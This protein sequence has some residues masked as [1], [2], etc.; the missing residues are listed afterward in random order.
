MKKYNY[1]Y[2]VYKPPRMPVNMPY[3]PV[4]TNAG[5]KTML[6]VLFILCFFSIYAGMIL[7]ELFSVKSGSSIENMWLLF[8]VLPLPLS[9]LILGIIFAGRGYKCKKNIVVG[10]IFSFLLVIY[11]SFTFTFADTY[12]SDYSFVEDIGAEIGVTMPKDGR[13]TIMNIPH[14]EDTYFM[15]NAEF[16]QKDE[17]VVLATEI[18]ADERWVRTFDTALMGE[19]PSVF[20]PLSNSDMQARH[21]YML[22]NTDLGTFNKVTSQSG[23]YRYIF[24]NYDMNNR[25]MMIGVYHMAIIVS[26]PQDNVFNELR[27]N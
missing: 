26:E 7:V 5:I 24:I 25:T 19:I 4:R 18:L 15:A 12:S 2:T 16:F 10:I 8:F 27:L 11:G 21:Y 22:Y 20:Q 14:G 1:P 23:T 6:I 17:T 3:P 13:V 9:S